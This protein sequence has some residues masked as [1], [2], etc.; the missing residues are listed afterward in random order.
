M[1]DEKGRKPEYIARANKSSNSD[2]TV[3][4]GAAWSFKD[5]EKDG[6]VV[7]LHSVPFNWDGSF[8]LV[9]R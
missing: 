6:Y 9:P 3:T 2:D 5:D 1:P 7:N 8:I 4:I